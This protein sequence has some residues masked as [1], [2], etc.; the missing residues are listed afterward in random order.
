[1]DSNSRRI[2]PGLWVV[3]RKRTG[4]RVWMAYANG[5]TYMSYSEDGARLWLSREQD[6]PEPEKAA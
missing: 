4:V 1:M 3:T 6:D 2:Q 5:I